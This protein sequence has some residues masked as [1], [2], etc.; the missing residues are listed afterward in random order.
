MAENEALFREINDRARPN[1]G[2]VHA[3]RGV[4]AFV[5]E[6]ADDGCRMLLGL[7]ADEYERVRS[8]PRWFIVAPAHASLDIGRVIESHERFEIVELVGEAARLAEQWDPRARVDAGGDV[9]PSH[10]RSVVA[11]RVRGSARR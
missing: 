7:S 1:T 11:R 8:Q 2:D 6:C 10:D 4:N 5:C 9:A 3:H